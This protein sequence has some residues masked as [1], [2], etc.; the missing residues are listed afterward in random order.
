MNRFDISPDT[1]NPDLFDFDDEASL[2]PLPDTSEEERPQPERRETL[3]GV[4]T[5]PERRTPRET[6]AETRQRPRRQAQ[7]QASRQPQREAQRQ[8]SRETLRQTPRESTRQT[9]SPKPRRRSPGVM[10]LLR[11]QRT[12]IFMGILLSLMTVYLLMVTLSYFSTVV[13][14]QSTVLNNSLNEMTFKS[15]EISNIG[16]PLGA[17]LSDLLIR[18]WLGISS[19]VLL[20]WMGVVS[21]SL[22]KVRQ[23]PFWPLTF[24][25]LLTAIAL[26]VIA[27]LVT[28]ELQ[29][30]VMWGGA[31]GH[32][33]NEYIIALAGLPG[34]IALSLL[35]ASL[36]VLLFINDIRHLWRL[37][38][39]RIEERRRVMAERRAAEA[40]EER[41]RRAAEERRAALEAREAAKQKA[42]SQPVAQPAAATAPKPVSPTKDE[43]AALTDDSQRPLGEVAVIATIDTPDAAPDELAEMTISAPAIELADAETLA[44]ANA[45]LLES[46]AAA[47]A[48]DRDLYDPRADLSRYRFPS[49]DLLHEIENTGARI[50]EEEQEANKQKIT[51]TLSDFGIEITSIS[52]TVGPTVTLYEITMVSGVKI[53]RVRNLEDDIALSLKALGVRIIAPI[54]GKGTIGIEVPNQIAQTVQMKSILASAAYQECRMELPMALGSTISNE[55]FIAD[56]AKMPHLL[57]AGATGMGKS[58]GL[59]VIVAS[60]LY[61]KHPAELKFVFVD[62]KMVEFSLYKKLSHHYLA[63]MPGEDEPIITDPMKVVATL[64][65]LCLEM[66]N[67][68]A[69]LMDASCRNL[70]EYNAKFRDRRLNPEKGHR[71][72]PYIVVVVDEF[73]DL[74][75]TAGREVETPISRIAA[76]A[77]AVGIHMILATQ[78]PS[79]NVITGVIKANFPGRMAFRVNQMVDSR[80]ILDRP[81]AEKLIGRGDMLFSNSGK[82]DRVQ[83]GFI[84]TDEVEQLCDDINSQIG[85]DEPYQLPEFIPE[86]SD[87]ATAGGVTT[88]RDP[89]FEESA[90]FVVL[91]STASTSSLQR[92]YSIGYNR[93]G[94]IMDQL[95]MAGIVG[96]SMGSKPRQVLVDTAHLEQYLIGLGIQQ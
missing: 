69:L 43:S 28:W 73:G 17:W 10:A 77:R 40:A 64:N 42:A 27:G 63:S 52:A 66:D 12:H 84:D 44:K 34:A 32:Y 18:R 25:C 75:L 96:P 46:G 14:D 33:L 26:S 59:N 82:I 47:A 13:H 1:Y 45:E 88:D 20:I 3:A 86:S 74:I 5:A 58:V 87:C 31:H 35:M 68:Y 90:R 85:Y 37:V 39:E 83:C 57:V 21:L 51:K 15:G 23:T 38:S 4:R 30:A 93:A 61:K 89:L 24:R 8:T 55:I 91:D 2:E 53:S 80:T 6:A 16:G 81:G 50:D 94:K 60:L 70:K 56:L 72:L 7:S 95:E 36:L 76:K 49:L 22:L 92:R 79:T 19:F 11:D 67:R 71:F 9:A 62:P 54:P 41:E 29:T 78:R 65:S 48:A